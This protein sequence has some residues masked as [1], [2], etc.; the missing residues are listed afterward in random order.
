MPREYSPVLIVSNY[1]DSHV[2]KVLDVLDELKVPAVRWHPDELPE[3]NQV[4]ADTGGLWIEISG[5]EICLELE[6]IRSAWYR[7]PIRHLPDPTAPVDQRVAAVER[8]ALVSAVYSCTRSN[9]WYSHPEHVERA[10]PKI[11]QLVVASRLG[12]S[13]PP[14]LASCEAGEIREFARAHSAVVVKALDSYS[15]VQAGVREEGTFIRFDVK[16][17][18]A[19]ELEQLGDEAL[20]HP[21]FVQRCI[22]KAFD[23]RLTVIGQQVYAVAIHPPPSGSLDWRAETFE[24]EHETIEPHSDIVERSKAYMRHYRLNYGAF[25]FAVDR[26]G[27]WW[28]LE[29]NANGQ[30]LW[31]ER[32]CKLGMTEVMAE[33]LALLRPPL[34]APT[35]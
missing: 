9:V 33:S 16:E 6:T 29:C 26:E 35:S 15:Q 14:Y 24:C 4:R 23:V 11:A 3:R 27:R 32:F 2:D 25:D 30:F 17:F 21:L 10:N 5:S 20:P 28:F 13:V 31:I 1:T 8:Q 22:D 18:S 19:E 12:L 34:V 7:K